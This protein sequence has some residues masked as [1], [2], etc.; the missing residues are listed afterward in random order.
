LLLLVHSGGS[1]ADLNPASLLSVRSDYRFVNLDLALTRS[2]VSNPSL[3]D[4]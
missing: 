1:L 4:P 3:K 2:A